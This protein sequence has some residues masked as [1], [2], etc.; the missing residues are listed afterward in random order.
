MSLEVAKILVYGALNGLNTYVKPGGVHRLR[1]DKLFD[2]IACNIVSILDGIVGAYEE[3][4][5]VRKGE[6]ALTSVELG[7][8]LARTYREAYRVCSIVHPGYFTPML[9]ASMALGYSGV[10]SIL[11]DPGKFK[12]SLDSILAGNKWGDIRYFIDSLKSIGRSDMNEHLASTG[13]TQVSL[14]QSGVSY[15]D[16]FQALGSRWPGFILLDP[17]ENLLLNGLRKLV[18]YHR[19]LKNAHAAILL[20]YLDL[21]EER[22][23]EQYREGISEAR[24]LGLMETH[25]GARKLFELDVSLRKNG[26]VLNGFVEQVVNLAALAALEGVR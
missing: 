8:I 10:E 2:E 13:L 24:R 19:K 21:V 12:R 5:R 14:I 16:V 25:E 23:G 7:R 4:E 6:K 18:E 26:I 1:P 20:L 3:G 17:R 11:S 9:I 22:L 15:T